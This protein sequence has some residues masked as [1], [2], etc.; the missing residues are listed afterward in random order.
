[1]TYQHWKAGENL[2][3][4]N[5]SVLVSQVLSLQNRGLGKGH[6]TTTTPRVS[7]WKKHNT[8]SFVG[9]GDLGR[10]SH[11]FFY[12]CRHQQWMLCIIHHV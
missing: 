2:L 8:L 4:R 1:V 11:V 12:V 7:T 3:F 6:A 9:T 5:V 10:Y